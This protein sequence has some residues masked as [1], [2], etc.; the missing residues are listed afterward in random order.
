MSDNRYYV[1]RSQIWPRSL[2]N[3]F[4]GAFDS[5]RADSLVKSCELSPMMYRKTNQVGVY[6]LTV[7]CKPPFDILQRVY[8]GN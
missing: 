2:G 8:Y 6:Y 4:D 7:S 5:P 1:K 3:Y